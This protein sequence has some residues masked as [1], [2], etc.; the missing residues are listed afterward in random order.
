MTRQHY[1]VALI[2]LV[3]SVTPATATEL[4]TTGPDMLSYGSDGLLSTAYPYADLDHF[5]LAMDSTVQQIQWSEWL[6]S[7]DTP[8]SVD[9]A[10]TTDL[11]GG[12]G[13]MTGASNV[14][15]QGTATPSYTLTAN[16][17]QGGNNIW[18]DTFG[19]NVPLAAG[20][21]YLWL[22]NSDAGWGFA[23]QKSGD[24]QQWLNGS[25][26][27]LASGDFSFAISDA[28]APSTPEPGSLILLGMGAATALGYSGWR[29]RGRCP[30]RPEPKEARNYRAPS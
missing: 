17:A 19:I 11:V 26:S 2:G 6:P 10:I 28:P 4:Y 9:W 16:G 1:L 27:H 23:N 25:F 3:A 12:S 15:A 14:V 7:G 5:T 8:G 20:T 29:R 13:S 22:G 18:S 21:Y 30:R 24:A